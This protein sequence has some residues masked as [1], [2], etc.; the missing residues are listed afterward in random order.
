MTKSGSMAGEITASNVIMN[1]NQQAYHHIGT[2]L[3]TLY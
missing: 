3:M 2:L 1:K